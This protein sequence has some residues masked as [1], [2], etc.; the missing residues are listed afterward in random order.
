[1]YVT[2]KLLVAR[3]VLVVTTVVVAVEIEVMVRVF[4]LP[5]R[6]PVPPLTRMT[7]TKSV[8]ATSPLIEVEQ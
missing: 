6:Y 2:V 8:A 4:V 5:I 3:A 1:M 7:T